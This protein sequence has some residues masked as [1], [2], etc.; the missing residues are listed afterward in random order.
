MT[1]HHLSKYL[2]NGKCSLMFLHPSPF[3][4]SS[5]FPL[6]AEVSHSMSCFQFTRT[7]IIVKL[8]IDV[9]LASQE[10]KPINVNIK[11]QS[12]RETSY[13]K[14]HIHFPPSG[15][16]KQLIEN[17]TVLFLKLLARIRTPHLTLFGWQ[18]A[19]RFTS[20]QQQCHDNNGRDGFTTLESLYHKP[21]KKTSYSKYHIHF[22]PSGPTKQLIENETVLFLK[23]LARIRTPH[24]ALFGWQ[25]VVRFNN[26]ATT[27]MAK[28]DLQRDCG[29]THGSQ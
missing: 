25:Q 6:P 17:E 20:P 15:P 2:G 18:Q 1:N 4:S 7:L 11:N 19:G 14:Y 28:L 10:R 16:T 9:K 23:L 27:T 29:R 22:P 13:S 3:L 8:E 21:K 12:E 5:G 24:L 26:N